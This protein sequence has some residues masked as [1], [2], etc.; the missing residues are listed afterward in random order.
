MS[1]IHNHKTDEVNSNNDNDNDNGDDN[2]DDENDD[3]DNDQ[4]DEDEKAG[5]LLFPATDHFIFSM[6][7]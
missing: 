1:N 7:F 2:D 3:D 6:R 4:Y 5:N